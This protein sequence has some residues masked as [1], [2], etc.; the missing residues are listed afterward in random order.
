MQQQKDSSATLNNGNIT[1]PVAIVQRKVVGKSD[2]KNFSKL[3]LSTEKKDG[4]LVDE[5]VKTRNSQEMNA[6]IGFL[7]EKPKLVN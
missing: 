6:D 2:S 4:N 7:I 3:N 1:G 5:I